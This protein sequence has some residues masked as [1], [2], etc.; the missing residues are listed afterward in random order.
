MLGGNNLKCYEYWSIIFK[1]S[2]LGHIWNL[3]LFSLQGLAGSFCLFVF[4]SIDGWKDGKL[5]SLFYE[6]STTMNLIKKE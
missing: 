1:A 3:I 6:A 4:E 2:Y 5:I